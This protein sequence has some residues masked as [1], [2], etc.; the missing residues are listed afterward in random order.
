MTRSIRFGDWVW[1]PNT[2]EL[3][4]GS[5]VAILEPRVARLFEYMVAHQ[6]EL[7][8][9]DRIVEAAWEGRI[10]SDEAVRHAVFSLRRALAEG[11]AGSCIRTIHKKGYIA[12][13]PAVETLE[14]GARA[15]S[16][17]ASPDVIPDDTG[18]AGPVAQPRDRQ[19]AG[20]AP[21]ARW[22]VLR[23]VA[24]AVI[25][26]VAAV[27]LLA[28]S[29]DHSPEATRSGA[30]ATGFT[31][32][33]VLPFAHA[34]EDA[35]SAFL[36]DGLAEELIEALARNPGLRVTA[37]NSAFQF[38]GENPDLRDVGRRL[39]VRYALEGSVS[40]SAQQVR[41]HARLIDTET[42]TQL[43]SQAYNRT[44]VDWFDLQQDLATEVARTLQA[45]LPRGDAAVAPPRETSS[46][47]AHL[48]VLRA[49][50][51]LA[52]RSVADAEQAIEHLQ[53]ALTL[54]PNYAQA[55]ARLADAILIKAESTTGLDAARPAVAPL[56]EKALAL[57]PGLGEA[58]ALRSMLAEDPAA[59]ERDLQRGLALNPSYARG[60]ELLA[61][62]Q[63]KSLKQF[64]AAVRSIDTAIALDPLT[65]G[66]FHAKA[67]LM[68][69]VGAWSEAAELE[70]RVLELNPKF[71]AALLRL[72]M[73]SVFRGD[74]AEAIDYMERAVA[75]DPRAVPLRAQLV[76][77][78]IGIGDFDAA[79]AVDDPP[80]ALARVAE[81]WADGRSQQIA[82]MIYSGV[83][84]PPEQLIPEL[85]QTVLVQALSDRD[86]SR[87]QALLAAAFPYADTL[88][89]DA[90]NWR[91]YAYANRVQLL[92]AAGDVAAAANLRQQLN[93]WMS[94]LEAR[95]P[96]YAKLN[97]HVRA[98]LLAHAGRGDEAC[99]AL[100]RSTT[101]A[102]GPRW[103]IVTS[104]PAFD[105]MRDLP[106]FQAL[107]TRFEAHT[108]Q[109]RAKVDAMRRSGRIPDRSSAR[110]DHNSGTAS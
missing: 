90:L 44:L 77:L 57:D 91:L 6:G 97:D 96:P 94:A 103:A 87:A 92:A 88:P 41:I 50:R 93:D 9:H 29:P 4:N 21:A 68:M 46:V 23:W 83:L 2:L 100:E 81:L 54:D 8:S 65:P 76:N 69:E 1:D 58:Y 82:D 33:A 101:P 60:Y 7:L 28:T 107:L 52:T 22:R 37:R 110:G 42:D 27:V 19:P 75:L 17:L 39:A 109:E 48:E 14:R 66:N 95:Y 40:R 79:L 89:P 26:I 34:G 71:R 12:T 49:R 25:L 31:T 63:V 80:T 51:L 98:T 105:G 45:V 10:V 24:A 43:W 72:S 86:F 53:Q 85:S 3:H 11:G 78:Y 61:G 99:A 62:V 47:E 59:A 106:C 18:A 74:F 84:G 67:G 32:I 16:S 35:D 5:K 70:R 55:Y 20:D 104:N 30:P 73:V 36:A 102:P 15:L 13:F 38:R 64:E 108:A 56:L